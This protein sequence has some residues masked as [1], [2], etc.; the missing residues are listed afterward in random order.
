V[1][2][3]GAQPCPQGVAVRRKEAELWRRRGALERRL[4]DGASLRLS[5]LALR[6][7]LLP[8]APDLQAGIDELQDEVHA[9]L[10]ELRQVSA[11]IYPPLLQQAGLRAALRELAEHCAVEVVVAATTERFDP[12]VEG[13]AFYAVAECVQPP[14]P[15]WPMAV[16]VGR[17]GADARAELM[18]AIV[19]ADPR[20]VACLEV[21]VAPLGGTVDLVEKQRA[22]DRTI[23][24][25]I[26]CG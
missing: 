21:Q 9:V 4:H 23:T 18:V 3:D 20:H 22:R 15:D 10:D 12:V 19:G 7:G 25:R 16:A 8:H 26:P 13:T 17:E 2:I 1:S 14:W 11:E 6:L 5:A 24:V